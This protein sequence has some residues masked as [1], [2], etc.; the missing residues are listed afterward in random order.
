[1]T[2]FQNIRINNCDCGQQ[3]HQID[4]DAPLEILDIFA[5]VRPADYTPP[6]P[7]PDPMDVFSY[8]GSAGLAPTEN[9]E[10]D[11]S[12]PLQLPVMNWDAPNQKTSNK[13]APTQN[14]SDDAP[15]ELPQMDWGKGGGR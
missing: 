3:G 2:Q 4:N 12:E 11:Q 13:Q 6:V 9:A 7:E 10:L 1:M 8:A 14:A 5:D 15:L